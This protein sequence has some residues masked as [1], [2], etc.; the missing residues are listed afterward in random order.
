[1]MRRSSFDVFMDVLVVFYEYDNL[2]V[3]KVM[4][5]ANLNNTAQREIIDKLVIMGVLSVSDDKF[6]FLN[7]SFE[8]KLN[9]II[10]NYKKSKELYNEVYK[11]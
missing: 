5:K 11:Q 8:E 9:V 2:R 6:F 7:K 4:R 1:M 10:V 3:D